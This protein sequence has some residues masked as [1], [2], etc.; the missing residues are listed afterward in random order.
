MTARAEKR[1]AVGLA[2]L[3]KGASISVGA[4]RTKKKTTSRETRRSFLI[5]SR[6]AG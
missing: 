3:F 6:D 1:R 4:A 5:R 2:V